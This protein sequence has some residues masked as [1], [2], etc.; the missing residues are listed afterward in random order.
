MSHG[1]RRLGGLAIMIAGIGLGIWV[2]FGPPHDW[3][4]AGTLG[5]MALGLG[6][7]ALISSAPSLIFPDDRP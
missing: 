3:H 7:L 4:G 1:L 5:R 2:V 6:S